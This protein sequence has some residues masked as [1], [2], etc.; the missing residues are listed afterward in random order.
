MFLKYLHQNRGLSQLTR[1]LISFL[2]LLDVQSW[3]EPREN[4]ASL[5]PSLEQNQTRPN[6]LGRCSA[7]FARL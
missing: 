7:H 3:E 1:N 5:P 2:S 4:T 6:V